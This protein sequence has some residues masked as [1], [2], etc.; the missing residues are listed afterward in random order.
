MQ[1][2]KQ[3]QRGD[4]VVFSCAFEKSLFVEGSVLYLD[5]LILVLVQDSCFKC[6]RANMSV[7]WFFFDS[8][9]SRERKL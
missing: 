2:H 8:W 5:V 3:Q 6:M 7:L 1:S 9:T 4:R